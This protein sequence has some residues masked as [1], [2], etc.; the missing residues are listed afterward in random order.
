VA[1]Q[2]LDAE[3][4]V[5]AAVAVADAEGL[6]AVTL[7]RLAADLDVRA[8]SLY[9]HV[10]GRE[11]VIDAIARRGYREMT[12]ALQ[13]AA[14][15]RSGPEAVRAVAAAYRAYGHAA[16]GRYTAIQRPLP[17]DPDAAA[18]VATIA[19][20]LRA[21]RLTGAAEIHAIRALRSALHGF[22]I[23][24]LTGG[25]ALDVSLDASYKVLVETVTAGLG[26][27]PDRPPGQGA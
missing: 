23:L 2:G 24:E 25:F 13:A 16:P 4:V 10:A 20:A 22:V 26:P 9:S 1:R 14:I 5:D 27:L 8:P 17:G 19:A 18:L 15:G 6:P 12:A 21:W 7:A 11:A 3:R